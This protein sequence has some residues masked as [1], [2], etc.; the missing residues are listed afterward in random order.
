[1]VANRKSMSGEFEPV[2]VVDDYY[3][4]PRN[5]IAEYRGVRHRF[6]SVVWPAGETWDSEDDR[7]ELLPVIGDGPAVIARGLFRARQPVP[8]LPPGESPLEV[9]WTIEVP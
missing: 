2:H 7:F 3:D 4:G 1:M 5:G 8:E 6:R 9:Q